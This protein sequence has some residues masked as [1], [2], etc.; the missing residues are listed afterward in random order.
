LINVLIFSYLKYFLALKMN[1]FRKA[2]L[3]GLLVCCSRFLFSQLSTD[4][5]LSQPFYVAGEPL[6]YSIL[7][8]DVPSKPI[9]AKVGVT[10]LDEQ[11]NP[12]GQH[13]LL[14]GSSAAVSG[15][16]PLPLNV[17]TG[18][19]YLLATTVSESGAMQVLAQ[20]NVPVYN[21]LKPLPAN[22]KV[23]EIEPEEPAAQL[24]IKFDVDTDQVPITNGRNRVRGT[25]RVTDLNGQPMRVLGALRVYDAR[26]F[27]NNNCLFSGSTL[28]ADFNFPEKIVKTGT[29]RNVQQQAVNTPLLVFNPLNTNRFEFGKSDEQGRFVVALNDFSAQQPWQILLQR[30]EVIEL[31]WDNYTAELIRQPLTLDPRITAY[32]V[33]SSQRRLINQEWPMERQVVPKLAA[34]VAPTPVNWPTKRTFQVQNYETFPNMA[35]FMHEVTQ[36]VRF[37]T[38]K[39]PFKATMYNLEQDRE[40]ETPPLFILDGQATFDADFIGHLPPAQIAT[41]EVLYGTKLLRQHYPALGAGGVIRLTSHQKNIALPPAE[42]AGCVQLS[43]LAPAVEFTDPATDPALPVLFRPLLAWNGTWAT[44][45]QGLGQFEFLDSNDRSRYCIEFTLKDPKTGRVGVHT[46]C[47]EQ[48]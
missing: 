27:G 26:F 36:I 33:A 48:R 46:T 11:G 25:V 38:Q 41:V 45:A 21:D 13:Y 4:M 35:T 15:V 34:Q 14:C 31:T 28:P 6:Q 30:G 5:V 1:N 42:A 10:L 16:F 23:A 3:L 32:M 37:N 39:T 43:G 20:A 24:S 9:L 17:P 8:P 7:L 29:V 40:F 44:N 12:L 19:Y 2:L 18:M 47:F 22:L